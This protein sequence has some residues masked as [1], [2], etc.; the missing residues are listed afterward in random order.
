MMRSVVDDVK[1][2][3]RPTVFLV[4]PVVT[5]LFCFAGVLVHVLMEARKAAL[6]RAVETATGLIAVLSTDIARN[7]EIINLSLQE[8]V[9]TLGDPGIDRID[10]EL[11]RR[12][13][14]DRSATA[15]H[16]GRIVVTDEWG[17]LQIDSRAPSPQP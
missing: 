12:L 7:I 13:L 11:R 3:G 1:S 10:P 17:D 14:F 9:D 15:R 16:L 6:E 5:L 2:L 4:V 8:V